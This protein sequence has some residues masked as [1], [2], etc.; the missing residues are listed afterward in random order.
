MKIYTFYTPS[1]KIFFDK[2]FEPS[3]TEKELEIVVKEIPQECET[4]EY[5]SDGWNLSMRRKLEYVIQGI[6]ENEG[7]YFI[8]SDCD[9]YF[10]NP[11]QDA[12]LS[13]AEGFD[14]VAQRGGGDGADEMCAGFFMC[15]SNERTFKLF[16]KCLE[17]FDKFDNDQQALDKCKSM[18]KY[19]TLPKSFFSVGYRWEGDETSLHGIRIPSY[20]H[21]FHGN[22]TDGIKNKISLM[23]FV[24][25]R[26]E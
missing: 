13:H 14:I 18:V 23:D 3:C 24:I 16:N 15:H 10:F 9:I 7:K 20:M 25:G 26:L 11:I 22:W 12:L 1:H 6:E 5:M 21:I 8:H 4:G 2:Y 19:R 17:D